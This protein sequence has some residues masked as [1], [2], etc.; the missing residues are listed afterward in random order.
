M[1]ILTTLLM[2]GMFVFVNATEVLPSWNDGKSKTNIV[3]Y[4][5]TVT[6]KNSTDFIPVKD[7]IAVFDNDGTLW[8][9][10]PVYFQFFF[11][12]DRVKALAPQHP[13]WKLVQPFKAVL[14]GDIKKV[15]ASGKE[16]LLKL[17]MVSHTGMSDE[18]FDDIVAAWIK[19][20]KHPTKKVRFTELVFQPMLELLSYLRA[21]GFKTFIVSGGGIDFMRPWA[22]EVYGIPSNRIIGSEIEV[23]YRDRKI[24]RIPKTRFI[25]D[26]EGKPVGIHYHIGKRPVAAFGNSDGDLD[27]MQYTEA[28]RHY[29]TLQLY[30]HHT[31][32]K[33]EWAYDRKSHIGKLDKGLDYARD[34]NWTVVDMKKEWK[35]IYPFELKH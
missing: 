10:Q 29:K 21:N 6:D 17:I 12:M 7:R 26:K 9:E 32:A 34:H 30:V 31:D 11:A 33:R 15:M 22:T 14:E 19:T 28:N 25:D 24:I 3:N 23:K 35:V 5:K 18:E 13:E 4:V 2:F 27:M 16:G 8:S 1:K 20:A